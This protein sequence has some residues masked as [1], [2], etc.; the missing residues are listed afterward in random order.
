MGTL[1]SSLVALLSYDSS[2]VVKG[3]PSAPIQSWAQRAVR[4]HAAWYA[5]RRQPG[6]RRRRGSLVALLSNALRTFSA[7]HG[8]LCIIIPFRP[9]SFASVNNSHLLL[10]L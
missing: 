10:S 9:K 1:Q 6:L 5:P 3:G 2:A 8:P 4:R 7:A